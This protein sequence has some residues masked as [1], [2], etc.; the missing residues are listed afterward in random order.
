M[1]RWYLNSERAA[2]QLRM[3]DSKKGKRDG[4]KGLWTP[5]P[6]VDDGKGKKAIVYKMK[7]GEGKGGRWKK[8]ISLGHVRRDS[9]LKTTLIALALFYTKIQ[10]LSPRFRLAFS[11]ALYKFIV[12]ASWTWI[13]HYF[14]FKT[15]LVLTTVI[16][17]KIWKLIIDHML[18]KPVT[19]GR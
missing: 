5:S 4:E 17:H 18:R 16:W 15:N 2:F 7:K 11:P 6:H 13:H 1:W 9:L 12:W 3:K 19:D 14:G 10:Y 8:I